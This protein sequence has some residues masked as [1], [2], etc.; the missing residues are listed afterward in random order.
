MELLHLFRHTDEVEAYPAGQVIFKAGDPGALM[1]VVLEGEVEVSLNN[2]TVE[3]VPPGGM[4]GELSLVDHSPR[5]AH[6][7]AKTDCVLAPINE[8]R[9]LFLVQETPYFALH[10]MSTMAERLRQRTQEA[11]RS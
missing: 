11:V 9:F 4:L 3:V 5:S 6:A 7:T 2:K 10:V 8:K 1:Y